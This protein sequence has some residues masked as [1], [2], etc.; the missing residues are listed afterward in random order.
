M[1]HRLRLVLL[2]LAVAVPLVG[3]PTPASAVAVRAGLDCGLIA[4]RD[5]T[6]EANTYT[7]VIEGGPY[8]TPGSNGSLECEIRVNSTAAASASVYDTAGIVILAPTL[9]SF[10][11][12]EHDAVYLCSTISWD[13]PNPPWDGREEHRSCDVAIR[14][15]VPNPVLTQYLITELP[16]PYLPV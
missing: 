6:S 11:A 9:V 7:G 13:N 3:A 4:L 1:R 14:I 12:S 8:V 16:D 15:E 10:N 2:S 5:Y